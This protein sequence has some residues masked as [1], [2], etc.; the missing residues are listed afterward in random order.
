MEHYELVENALVYIEDNIEESLSLESVSNHFNISKFYFHRL[1][2]AM[3][4]YS[5]NNYLLSRRLNT[6]VS[7]IQNKKLSLTDVAYRLNFG[8][9]SSFTRA[10]K[11]QYGIAP[12]KLK[13]NMAKINLSP[14]PLVVKKQ[15][16]NINGDIVTDFTLEEFNALRICGIAF[17]VDLA[18]ENYKLKIRTHSKMLL[19][20]INQ[21]INGPCY[22][23]YS[24]C[25]P[26][27]TRFN[28][29]FGIPY[30]I[31]INKPYY[32]T[33][34]VPSIF[35]A[36]FKYFGDILDIGDVLTTDFAR[37]LKIS[38]LEEEESNI[39]MIQAFEN[40]HQLDSSYHLYVPIKKH[41]IDSEC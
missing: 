18:T 24:N 40:V 13:E 33:D 3:T 25:Q 15:I 16:K 5:F 4:G 41:P 27:S 31:Q 32:F 37:F 28:V 19:D 35:C 1:F 23:I 8:T 2:S 38:K 34:D 39:E 7:L 10:F 29:L 14:I 17:E 22:V 30:D 6:S 36:K 20:N 26:N 21:T 11:R 12:S 9:P